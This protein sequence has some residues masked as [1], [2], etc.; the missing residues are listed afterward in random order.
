[1]TD[2]PG[3]WQGDPH[4]P[5]MVETTWRDF[6]RTVGGTVVEDVMPQPRQ[7]E[8]ADFAF[9]DASVVAEL[10]EIETEFSAAP[11]FRTGFDMLT[12]KLVTEDSECRPILFGGT[13]RQP[14]WFESE[15]VRLFRP[16]L[17]RILK[18]A[19]RQHC[20]ATHLLESGVD[21]HTI[22]RLLGHG[23]VSTTMRYFHLAH[24]KLTGTTSPLELLD[25]VLR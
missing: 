10:K 16:P 20:F 11:A 5:I 19:N 21:I 15:F 12:R 6:V 9:L 1:M 3:F 14:A 13:G 8:N 25:T 17:S 23:H 7:I 22:Q 18:K 24:H 4:D 2:I